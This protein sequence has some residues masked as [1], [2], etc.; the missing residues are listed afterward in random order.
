[1]IKGDYQ[2]RARGA[3]TARGACDWGD[4]ASDGIKTDM[5]KGTRA[6]GGKV[7]MSKCE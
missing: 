1:M 2:L 7:K 5:Y 6:A 3:L 4:W